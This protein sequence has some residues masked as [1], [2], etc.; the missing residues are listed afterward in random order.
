MDV[1]AVGCV[2]RDGAA[3]RQ[4]FVVRVGVDE[5]QTGRFSRRHRR[6]PTAKAATIECEAN[7]AV[8]TILTVS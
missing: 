6:H 1:G 5:E 3:G 4:R 2:V 8:R 7:A